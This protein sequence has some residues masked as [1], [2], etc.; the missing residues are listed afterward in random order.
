MAAVPLACADEPLAGRWEG[1]AQIPGRELRLVI[2]LAEERGEWRGS[3]TLPGTAVKGAALA[4]L[5]VTNSDV[6]FT[7]KGALADQRSGPAQVK[8]RVEGGRLT[9]ELMQAGH[10]AAL[11]LEKIGPAQVEPVPRSTAIATEVEGEWK[12][13]YELF[14]YPRTVTIKFHNR[15]A[16]GAT[17][18]FVIVGKRENKLP[19]DLVTQEGEFLTVRSA[20]SGLS[21]E[22]RLGKDAISGTVIQ[23]PLEIPTVLK[24][25]K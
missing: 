18:E 14:G 16:Q 21:F 13:S 19:V 17:A 10:S 6:S 20:E 5:N 24:R 2:D 22:G 11:A 8:A 9:G 4:E 25:A 23:G 15:G 12:G 3:I 7:I 1:S